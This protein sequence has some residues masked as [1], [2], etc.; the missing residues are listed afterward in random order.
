MQERKR[1]ADLNRDQ[2]VDLLDLQY[3]AVSM[4]KIRE[5]ADV[6]AR[7]TTRAAADA[8]GI[9]AGKNTQVEGRLEDVLA[10]EGSITLSAKDG[11][12]DFRGDAGRNRYPRLQLRKRKPAKASSWTSF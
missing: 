3:Y 2:A 11:G 12:E 1:T 7:L 5:K 6:K 10:S 9:G 8:A 4:G